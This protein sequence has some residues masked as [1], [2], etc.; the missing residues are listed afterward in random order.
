MA[1]IPL[2]MCEGRPPAPCYSAIIPLPKKT[3]NKGTE[4]I[5]YIHYFPVEQKQKKQSTSVGVRVGQ[6]P[7]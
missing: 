6:L 3:N 4:K 2:A 1:E 7:P 5:P